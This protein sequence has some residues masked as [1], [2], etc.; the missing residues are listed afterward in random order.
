VKTPEEALRCSP[1]QT[2]GPF[3]HFALTDNAALGCLTRP[4]AQGERIR[5]RI[6]LFDGD[7][8]P[9]PDGMLELW[10]ADAS[11]RYDHPADT[12]D[13]PPDPAFCG[14]G[15]LATDCA[16]GCIFETVYP[17]RV[18]DGRGGRQAPHINVSVFARGLLDRLCTR[19]YFADDAALADDLVLSLVPEERRHTLL[20]RRDPEQPSVWNFT[21]RLQGADE[22]V[23]FDA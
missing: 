19:I 13:R 22:T 20:A 17:G 23:F 15:R 1:S 8:L 10:Q 18:P 3:Y 4:E 6:G 5:L 7:G 21:I 14:F 2:I 9:A 12:Q 11:G 16:G